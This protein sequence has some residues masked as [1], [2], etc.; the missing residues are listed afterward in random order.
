MTPV[1]RRVL[2]ALGA[3]LVLA[4]AAVLLAWPRAEFIPSHSP[5]AWAPSAQNI[6]IGRASCRER[7]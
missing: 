7:V 3:L 5:Q 4:L 1:P 6:E 2:M